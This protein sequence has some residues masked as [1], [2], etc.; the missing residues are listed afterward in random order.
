MT[1]CAHAPQVEHFDMA[2][3]SSPTTE[4]AYTPPRSSLSTRM[5]GEPAR[6]V[7]D[8]ET[9]SSRRPAVVVSWLPDRR[10]VPSARRPVAARQLS[11]AL[12][13]PALPSTALAHWPPARSLAR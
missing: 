8:S 6:F 2:W 4:V 13:P 9:L 12:A 11:P 5:V 7:D 3:R 1:S 10:P